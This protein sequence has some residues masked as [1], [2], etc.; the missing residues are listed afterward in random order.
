MKD[1]T[2][3][4]KKRKA[5]YAVYRK[6]LEEGRFTS[7]RNAGIYIS[8]SSAPCFFISPERA[9]NLVGN[10]LAGKSIDNLHKT[11]QRMIRK[12][13]DDYKQYLL[14]HPDTK[15]SRVSIMNILVDREAPEFYMTSGSVRKELREEIRER[16]KKL[17]W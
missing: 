3:R 14:D 15:L 5:L 17:G 1:S 11:K 13:A 8:H 4:R 6:G 12:L 7:M 10:V 9:S 16:R 2:L